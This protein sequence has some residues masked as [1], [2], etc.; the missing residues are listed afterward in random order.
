[1]IA[2]HSAIFASA[3]RCSTFFIF[4]EA[5]LRL[6]AIFGFSAVGVG[7]A[8]NSAGLSC[9]QASTEAGALVLLYAAIVALILSYTSLNSFKEDANNEAADV[10]ALFN[11]SLCCDI[12]NNVLTAM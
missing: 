10:V 8:S 11:L 7:D 9:L 3:T 6:L 4:A 12:Y 1:M 2:N 5:F